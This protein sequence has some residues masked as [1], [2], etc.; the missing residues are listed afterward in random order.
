MDWQMWGTKEHNRASRLNANKLH[1][2]TRNFNKIEKISKF[3]IV[4]AICLSFNPWEY[5]FKK[6]VIDIYCNT[7][8]SFFHIEN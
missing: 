8:F 6:Y 7:D 4:A 3:K 2:K 5:H 1:G